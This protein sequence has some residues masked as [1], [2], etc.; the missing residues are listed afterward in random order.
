MAIGEALISFA[1]RT[2]CSCPP[3]PHFRAP[4]AVIFWKVTPP[5]MNSSVTPKSLRPRIASKFRQGRSIDRRNSE[6]LL[7]LIF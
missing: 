2:R 7:L 3:S 4:A 5:M 1:V 6:I